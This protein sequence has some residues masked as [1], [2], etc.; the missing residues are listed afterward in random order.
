MP[1]DVWEARLISACAIFITVRQVCR[2]SVGFVFVFCERWR[3]GRIGVF[4]I[5]ISILVTDFIVHVAFLA[6]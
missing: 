5:L 2:T 4:I 3:E 1:K 6:Q